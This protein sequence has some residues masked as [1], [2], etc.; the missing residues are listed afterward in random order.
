MFFI[1]DD[2]VGNSIEILAPVGSIDALYAAVENGADAVYLGGKLFNARQ[3]A[4]NFSDEDL[5][6]AVE[7]AHLRNVKVYVT[8]NI[9]LD[10]NELDEVIDYLVFLYNIDV[11]A[12]IVQDLGLARIVRGLLPDFEIH[13]STQMSINNYMGVKFLE[14]LGF[15]RV[16]LARELS[17]DE[18]RYIKENTNAELEAFI[19]GALCVCYSGQCLM[20]SMIGGRS[21]NRGRCA[22]PC[23][24]AYSIVDVKTNKA[25][26]PKFEEKYILSPKD[27]NTIEYL[28]E[29]IDSGITSLKIEGR[30]KKPE[31]VATIVSSYRKEINRILGKHNDKLTKKDI[32]D[33]AQ[34]FNR[35]FTKGYLMGDYGK[36][37][38]SF[39]K[40]NN[41]GVYIGEVVKIDKSFC[42]IKLEDNLGKGDGIEIISKR[43]EGNGQIIDK[44]FDGNEVVDIGISGMTIKIKRISGIEVGDKVFKTFDSILNAAAGETYTKKENLKKIL[45]SMAVEVKIGKPMKLVIWMDQHYVNVISN[46]I[47][48]RGIKLSLDKEKIIKQMNKLGDTPY[49]LESIDVDLED[50]A[51]VPISVL[52]SLRREGIEELNKIRSSFNN[53]IEIS[54]NKLNDK[55]IKA[56]NYPENKVDRQRKLS[57]KVDSNFQF[58]QLDISKLDR[59]Y[60]SYNGSIEDQIKEIKKYK[61]EIY[62]ATEKII[63]NEE[64]KKLENIFDKIVDD[65][66]GISVSNIG[67]LNFVGSRYKTKI[68][69]DIGLNIF[70]SSTVKLLTENNVNSLT[71]SPELK[72]SQITDICKNNNVEYEVIGYGYFPIMTT[73]HCPMSLVKGC[74]DDKNCGTCE[75]AS[76]Y[77]LYDRKGMTFEMKRKRNSTIIYN[78]QPLMVVEYINKIFSAGIDMMRLDFTIEKDD[79]KLIQELYYNYINDK[80]DKDEMQKILSE[81]KKKTG[82]T[83]GHF[84]RGVL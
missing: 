36:D 40:P 52:N 37:F 77:G 53:R 32:R 28:N 29:I 4:S 83:T 9:L 76:G 59:I 39:D 49:L 61:K 57:I 33:M 48:E 34:M 16:V 25:I 44:I 38:I 15:K 51:M 55:I 67:T 80:I 66:D 7:Y 72:L 14:E 5:K 12:L 56:F 3:Y 26:S 74:K 2:F 42:H 70:N 79:I 82:N 19:H 63:T 30:M 31:Y 45:I 62:I 27:L 21:G 10:D 84:F 1:G 50:G 46:E 13:G 54:T 18:I 69:C 20:S 75:L 17:I 78:S 58:Q 65:V 35:G 71:L 11:D 6:N 64:F 41:R 8:V 24:M 23:R 73:K 22:Q 60:L 47:V 81:L 43:G 68:H